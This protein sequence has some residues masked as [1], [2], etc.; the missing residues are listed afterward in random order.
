MASTGNGR[1]QHRRRTIIADMGP[2]LYDSTHRCNAGSRTNADDRGRAIRREAE[3]T[4]LKADRELVA[5]CTSISGTGHM[6][7]EA[8]TWLQARHV[9]RTEST[10]EH[11]KH[12]LVSDDGDAEVNLS[13]MALA[14]LA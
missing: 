12:R 9:V 1:L 10:S 3:K 8:R 5:C 2:V 7:R 13:W 6:D 11:A 4:L 14:I